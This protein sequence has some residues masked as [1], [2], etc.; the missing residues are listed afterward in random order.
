MSSQDHEVLVKHLSVD[1]LSS[2]LE[3]TKGEASLAL[4]LYQWNSS[5]SSA[6][7]HVLGDVEIVVRNAVDVEMQSLNVTLGNQGD[8]FDELNVGVSSVWRKQINNAK[9]Y[10]RNDGKFLT[11]SNIVSELSFGFW[12][13][14]LTK[15]Y[16]DTLWREAL[17]FA[18]PH[19]PS[20]QPEYIFTRVRH[21]HVLRNRI[22]HHEPIHNRDIARDYQ[23]CIE[24]LNSISPI[25]AAWSAENSRVVAVLGDRPL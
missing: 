7:F 2:Y 20:R 23:I 12:R 25:I 14:F 8:W 24:V 13:S 6:M 4:A 3:S 11:H 1:R 5:V 16:K 19:S 9:E 10:L 22:A 21:L 17:R 18:F 15:Q